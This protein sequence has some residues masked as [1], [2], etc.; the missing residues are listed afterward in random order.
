MKKKLLS[1][2]AAILIMLLVLPM[3]AAGLLDKDAVPP[4]IA[5]SGS[6]EA[7]SGTRMDFGVSGGYLGYHR[8]WEYAFMKEA[9]RYGA[10]QWLHAH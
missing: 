3:T 7:T 5:S 6:F 2:L 10:S 4:E 8:H 1:A 9:R